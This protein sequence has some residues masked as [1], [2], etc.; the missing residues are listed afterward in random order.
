MSGKGVGG[1]AAAMSI[2]LLTDEDAM[3]ERLGR[4]SKLGFDHSYNKFWPLNN[5]G[6][7]ASSALLEGPPNGKQYRAH[8]GAIGV[9]AGLAN[10]V[11][12][13]PGSVVW[14]SWT[15]YGRVDGEHHGT[16]YYSQQLQEVINKVNKTLNSKLNPR[17]GYRPVDSTGPRLIDIGQVEQSLQEMDEAG[18]LA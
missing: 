11:D 2:G 12:A 17:K 1:C 4:S 3:L 6:L 16:V 13:E 15:T 10:T 5:A 9:D 7:L 18:L 14:V 8:V